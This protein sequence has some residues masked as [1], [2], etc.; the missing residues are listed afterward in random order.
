MDRVSGFF[1]GTNPRERHI[2]GRGAVYAPKGAR[3]R[4]G[5]GQHCRMEPHSCELHRGG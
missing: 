5:F 3:A 1:Q 4:G 2:D